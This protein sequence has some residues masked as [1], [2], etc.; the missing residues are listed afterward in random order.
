[1]RVDYTIPAQETGVLRIFQLDVQ[2]TGGAALRS[3]L[4]TK[5]DDAAVLAA[6]AFGVDS[7][8]PW[9]LTM[10]KLADIKEMGLRG[11]LSDVQNV[12][13]SQ[14]EESADQLAVA[15]GILLILHSPALSGMAGTLN[16]AGFLTPIVQL[17][18][19][20]E[21]AGA[22]TAPA[23]KPRTRAT[24][25]KRKPEPDLPPRKDVNL[26]AGWVVP[27]FMAA[28]GIFMILMVV[29]GSR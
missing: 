29:F 6:K 26:L 8:D 10:V 17:D 4:V 20:H 22:D 1:M 16:P 3:A 7:V 13:K 27:T 2:N 28:A 5:N 15:S 23:P 11:Y 25:A 9:W 19:V 24:R 18:T 21:H 12:P 14:V